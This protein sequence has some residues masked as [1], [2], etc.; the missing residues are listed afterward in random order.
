MV[1]SKKDFPL[2][3]AYPELSYLDSA[4]TT[5][6][7]YQVI[8]AV[9]EFYKKSN[10]QV[11]RGIYELEERATE[12][13]EASRKAIA[14]YC[15]ASPQEIIF[16]QGTTEGINLIASSWAVQQLS[17]GDE[18]IISELEHHANILP[19][20]RL[21]QER[22]VILK[23][24][25]LDA[26]G[27]LN[28]QAYKDMLSRKTKLVSIIHT[29]N[30]LGTHVDLPL[31]ISHAKQVGA[32]VLVDATQAAG[33]EHLS[34]YNLGAD[35]VAFSG[36]KMLG[37]TGIGVLY[38]AEHIQ[39]EVVPYQLGGGMVDSVSFHDYEPAKPPLK[40]EAG[41]PPIAQVIGLAA[42]VNY[43][44]EISFDQLRAQEARLCRRLIEGLEEIPSIRMLG[45]LDELKKQG[46]MVSF[47]SSKAHAHDL[48]AFLDKAHLCLR[49][50]NHCAQPLHN[51]LG[52]DASVRASFYGYT[53]DEDIDHLIKTLHAS[54]RSF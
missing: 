4:A 26:H 3:E 23:Y 45:P 29:S 44:S 1:F 53:T 34:L 11:Y 51:A 13:Y 43:L 8:D 21:E 50:G 54:D 7:P 32:R 46:H 33:R 41:T 16:T 17:S 18:I 20:I 25:P 52:I 47:V 9:T 38:I 48:A 42:A 10:A 19:W 40:Y 12:K 49:A 2:L 37:P 36:H 39:Q 30:V 14:Q 15:G 6:K 31:I 35:F 24:I 27:S 22:G 28:Y 5:Q